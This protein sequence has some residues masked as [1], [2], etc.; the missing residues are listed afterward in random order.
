MNRQANKWLIFAALMSLAASL[1]HVGAILGGGDWYRFFGAGEQMAQLAEAGSP[2]P[3]IMT[4]IIA[5]ILAG[6]AAIDSARFSGVS[7]AS[8][9]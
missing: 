7:L 1:A 3:A 9:S 8:R 5:S 6:I 2:R 4:A